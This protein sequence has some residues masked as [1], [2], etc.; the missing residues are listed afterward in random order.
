MN[1]RLKK[2]S[3]GE[4]II[5]FEDAGTGTVFIPVCTVLSSFGTLK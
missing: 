4:K 5:I 3:N 1:G 2:I